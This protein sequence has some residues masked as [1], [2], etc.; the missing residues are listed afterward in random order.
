[1][2]VLN[3]FI[4]IPGSGKTTHRSNYPNARIICPDDIRA[5]LLESDLTGLYYNPA[6]EPQVWKEA[7]SLLV[8]FCTKGIDILWDATN[9]SLLRRYRVVATARRFNYFIRFIYFDIPLDVILRRNKSRKDGR[10]PVPDK[11]IAKMYEHLDV[12]LEWEYDALDVIGMEAA[13]E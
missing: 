4:G 12:P 13:R 6:I 9:Y 5:R 2:A 10:P 7:Y 3:L 11:V 8:Q 1:M